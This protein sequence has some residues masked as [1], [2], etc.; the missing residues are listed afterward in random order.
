VTHSPA[1]RTPSRSR[2]AVLAVVLGALVLSGCSSDDAPTPTPSESAAESPGENSSTPPGPPPEPPRDGACYDLTVAAADNLASDAEPVDCSRPHTARTVH[3]GRL[4]A[5]TGDP[6]VELSD[7][8]VPRQLAQECPRRVDAFLGGDPVTRNLSRFVAIWFL[9]T[10]AEADAGASWFRCDVVA[11]GA[12]DAFAKL[13]QQRLEGVLA[14]DSA[15][16]TFGT[17]GTAAPGTRGFERVICSL[18][19]S[20]RALTTIRIA[21][22]DRYPGVAEVRSSGDGA[23]ADYVE[24]QAGLT[25]EIDYGWEWP[26]QEQWDAG[27]RYGF[28]WAPA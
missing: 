21:D 24:G 27:Q 10:R 13:P 26:T 16:D 17:C 14:G 20:W 6:D 9:P 11:F 12:D 23:C 28:C 5:L 19:H 15:L 3:V 22:S 4:S 1:R 7:A 25:T 18:P 8:R 2:A